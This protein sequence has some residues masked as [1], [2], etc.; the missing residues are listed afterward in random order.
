MI[1]TYYTWL[2]LAREFDKT[3]QGRRISEAYSQVRDELIIATE[4][5]DSP[6]V[7]KI[8]VAKALRYAHLSTAHRKARK[9]VAT[10]FEEA[11]G[12]PVRAVFVAHR[13][14]LLTIKL[15]GG[16]EI[17]IVPFGPRPN[18][19]LVDSEGTIMRAFQQ[20]ESLRGQQA[21]KARSAPSIDTV[22]ALR[23]RWKAG[24]KDMRQAAS[25]A[26]PLFDRDLAEELI[27]RADVFDHDPAACDDSIFHKV[28]TEKQRLEEQ[29]HDPE[30]RIYGEGAT[31]RFSLLP[32]M[33]RQAE[34]EQQFTTVMEAAAAYVRHLHV[35][36]AFSHRYEALH[37][38]VFGNAE[39]LRR[40]AEEMQKTL[41]SPSRASRY[42][43]WG[44][45]L[46]AAAHDLAR[47]QEEARL[48]NIL[49]DGEWVTIPLDPALDPFENA[50]RYYD[51]ARRSREA[52]A[53]AE[54]RLKQAKKDAEEAAKL[55]ARLK[56]TGTLKELEAFEKEHTEKV[57]MLAD[58]ATGKSDV[59][60]RTYTVAGGLEVWVGR[61]ANQ[62]DLLTQR[63]ARKFDLWLHARGVP[64]SHVVLRLPN[65]TYQLGREAIEGA[66]AIAA[67]WSDARTSGL[68][69]VIYT[70]RKYVR[71]PRGAPPGTV[72]VER[73][74]VVMVTPAVPK[75]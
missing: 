66:A 75:T 72:R 61:N 10:L 2:A 17:R 43:T 45:L 64:G 18:I 32:L 65:K 12:L 16:M 36:A 47:G 14:R 37:Q 22:D 27:V 48:R 59:P 60:F 25:R 8:S 7:L 71:K 49:E 28:L 70:E 63:H 29:L 4:D 74:Q 53:H 50:K 51:K 68:A 69:P 6:I 44:H 40:R 13:D 56:G 5:R 58:R 19:F 20:D 30:P 55:V 31:R 33:S 1:S 39:R 41:E 67:W 21:P 54:K 57:R 3:L 24:S 9:N 34:T 42:E 38:R 15:D 46:M 62:N 35:H 11:T 52:R 73:E 26:F 23:D